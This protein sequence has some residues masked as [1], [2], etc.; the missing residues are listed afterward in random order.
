M[1][2]NRDEWGDQN[3]SEE[4]HARLHV[5][6]A[7][8]CNESW[9]KKDEDSNQGPVYRFG[10]YS[11]NANS[12]TL[13]RD[14]IDQN[15]QPQPARVLQFL[16][17][18]RGQVVSRDRIKNEIWGDRIVEFDQGLN[19]CVRQIR[20][21][22]GESA[23]DPSYVETIPRKGYR[24]RAEVLEA[25]ESPREGQ[26]KLLFAGLVGVVATILA[27][28]GIV[29][30]NPAESAGQTM[31]AI[32]PFETVG[33]DTSVNSFG[34]GLTDRLVEF[35]AREGR[36]IIG[37]IPPRATV[38]YSNQDDPVSHLSRELHASFLLTGSV[39]IEGGTTR[40]SVQLIRTSDRTSIWAESYEDTLG[41]GLRTQQN[42]AELVGSEVVRHLLSDARVPRAGEAI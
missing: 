25:A 9:M 38:D 32:L 15:L 40:I 34:T 24:F 2:C 31:L 41:S 7:P 36:S 21:R 18:N 26:R 13:A 5:T 28:L 27:V 10:P 33:S 35:T 12:G 42:I 6:R 16:I 8:A 17:E 37:V 30:S 11:F 23:D 29:A 22:L 1:T 19:Y 3:C 4:P 39:R 14:G 20:Q